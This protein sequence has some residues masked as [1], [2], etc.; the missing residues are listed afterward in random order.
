MTPIYYIKDGNLSFADKVILSDLELYLYTG[1]KICLIGRNGCGKSSLMKVISGD[2]ELDNGA[3]FQDPLVT[4]GYLRQDISIKTHLTVYDFVLQQT[5]STKEIDKYQ[6]DI[7]LEKLQINGTDNLSTYSGGQLRRASLAKALILEP[8]ILLLDEP[9]NHLDIAIIEWLEEFVKSYNGAIICVSHDRTFLSNVTNKIWWLD[10]GILR[11]SDK[12]FKFFDEWQTIIIDQ[13]EAALRKL[14]KK[15]SQENEWLNAGVT[16]RRK[17]NQKR[18]ADLKALRTITQ[19]QTAKL[20]SSTQRV[21]AELAENIAKSKFIIEADNITFSYKNTKIINNFSFRVK[22]GEK[23]GIIGANGS[24]KSTFIKLLTKQ[25]TPES[26]KIIYGGNLDISYFDQHREKLEPN[27]T[28]QQTLCPTG[29][30]QVFLPHGKTMHVAGY[31]KQF[32]F[33]PKL[34]N[35]KTAILS[36]GEANRLLLAKILINPGNLLILDEPTNDLDMD[37]L[38]ILLDILT[39]YSGTLIV[40]SHDRDFLDRLVTRTL[41][42]AQGKIH[43]LTGGYE[44]YKQYFTTSPIAKKASKPLPLTSQKEPLNKKLSYK[45]QRLLETLPNYIEKLEISIKHLEK[46][47]EDVNLYLDNPQKYNR[48]T[49]QLINDKKK[50]DELLNQWL[51][52]QD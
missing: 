31:L 22:N 45:Y 24:G 33:N 2:Y 11:K 49:S 51:E 20:A 4:T 27:H 12:G 38:E 41:V 34:L 52:I 39:D 1:D 46:E 43:D 25:L 21:R 26:G 14:N 44:D 23:I 28:L 40:V 35:A 19:E 47:L 42:F 48:I 10:R 8:E 37:S 30:D 7:I 13:E 32:M 50:L 36:G 29:G 18:L 16:A 6:I 17:R 3:L 15:L 5:D 9:T